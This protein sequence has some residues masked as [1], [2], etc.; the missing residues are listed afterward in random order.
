MP[1]IEYKDYK[2]KPKKPVR[3]GYLYNSE[4]GHLLWYLLCDVEGKTEKGIKIVKEMRI[5]NLK[6]KNSEIGSLEFEAMYQEIAKQMTREKRFE[7]HGLELEEK[8]SVFLDH[9]K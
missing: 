4:T 6:K 2:S 7:K 8:V 3:N 5:P 9:K 1:I